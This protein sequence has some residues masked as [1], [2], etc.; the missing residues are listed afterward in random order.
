MMNLKNLGFTFQDAQTICSSFK[1]M[2]LTLGVAQHAAKNQSHWKQIVDALF[3][4]L[5]EE[6]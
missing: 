3:S 2:G 1:E 5:D 4:T 6:D